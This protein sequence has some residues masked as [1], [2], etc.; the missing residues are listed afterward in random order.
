MKIDFE[1]PLI[2]TPSIV[3]NPIVSPLPVVVDPIVQDP[4]II[5]SD[6]IPI[7]TT[8]IVETP[9]ASTLSESPSGSKTIK[10]QENLEQTISEE[11]SEEEIGWLSKNDFKHE[12]LR[13]VWIKTIA[14]E[15]MAILKMRGDMI[16]IIYKM[17]SAKNIL[18]TMVFKS[19]EEFTNKW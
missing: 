16:K 8:T 2:S 10:V 1:L 18:G 15:S 19:F 17:T 4:I 5:K 7:E 13:N 9:S 6:P 11:W 3:V 14:A 12:K